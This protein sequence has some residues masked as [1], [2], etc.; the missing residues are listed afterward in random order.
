LTPLARPP[1]IDKFSSNLASI[2][3]GQQVTL[4]W[5]TQNAT[6]ASI[7]GIG[8]VTP[9]GSVT[10]TPNSSTTYTLRAEGP[11]GPAAEE[12]A[13]VTVTNRPVPKPTAQI[14]AQPSAILSGQ[15]STLVWQTQNATSILIENGSGSESVAS[16]GSKQVSPDKTTT[17]TLMARG[18][19]ES[20]KSQ[21]TIT[22]TPKPQEAQGKPTLYPDLDKVK[23]AIE[24]YR[25]AYE[26]LSIAEVRK[27]WPG[28]PKKKEKALDDSFKGFRAIKLKLEYGQP[29]IEDNSAEW[30]CRQT[31]TY[32][33][34]NGTVQPAIPSS[35]V[36]VL[37]KS[38]GTW[39]VQDMHGQ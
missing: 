26:T 20:V 8:P 29:K 10:V 12:R 39:Y 5:Q 14:D 16:S 33:A 1:R 23:A 35:V 17:Y 34:T 31:L 15:T 19:S 27:A 22:V 21:A 37:R 28:I 7:N 11:G 13:S 30:P 2:E 4:T 9:S 36:F 18:A 3:P 6:T 24:N 32:T 38:G 25:E